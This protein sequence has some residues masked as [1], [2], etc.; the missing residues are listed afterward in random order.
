M[1]PAALEP[2]PEG[3]G[4]TATSEGST[5]SAE[6]ATVVDRAELLLWAL[7]R[8]FERLALER[9]AAHS[10][11]LA[12]PEKRSF[13]ARLDALP[14]DEQ[15]LSA[16]ELG[17]PVEELLVHARSADE[18]A[19]LI[20]QGLVLEQL[21]R[22][23]YRVAEG[24][25]RANDAT[26]ALAAQG[27]IASA[28]VTAATSARV[29]ECVGTGEKLYAVFA[30]RSHDVIAALDALA[31]PV[32]RVFGERFGLR[33]ADVMGEFAAELITACTALGMQ[34]R[35]IVAHLAGACMGI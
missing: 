25:D 32:D 15:A 33:F 4:A 23:I 34:R 1:R 21:G 27:G 8:R 22:A 19:T 28:S 10:P 2:K 29:A 12:T 13:V 11:T 31:E 3:G 24:T 9:Y 6:P 35:K 14:A 30:E 18:V 20:V 7:M 26:R 5:G 17:R 16:S